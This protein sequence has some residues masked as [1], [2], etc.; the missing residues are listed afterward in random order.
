MEQ[1]TVLLLIIGILLYAIGEY[2][3]IVTSVICL[4]IGGYYAIKELLQNKKQENC[5]E[6]K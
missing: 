3:S 2:I 5:K 6:V 1:V 4:S